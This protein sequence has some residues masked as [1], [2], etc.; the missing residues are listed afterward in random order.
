MKKKA[1]KK[2]F[3]AD[4]YYLLDDFEKYSEI[5]KDRITSSNRQITGVDDMPWSAFSMFTVTH[6][7]ILYRFCSYRCA[8]DV[9][10][11]FRQKI[12]EKLQKT[13]CFYYS[14]QMYVLFIIN[15]LY[16][17]HRAIFF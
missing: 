2:F 15:C 13:G 9:Q 1:S 3:D 11:H 5:I 12:F 10:L 14:V 7:N 8:E 6:F 4:D 17:C 16:A